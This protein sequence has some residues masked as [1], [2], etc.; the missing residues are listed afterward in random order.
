MTLI[1]DYLNNNTSCDLQRKCIFLLLKSHL[2]SNK[3]MK[4]NK[5]RYKNLHMDH[6]LEKKITKTLKY[7][8]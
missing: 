4:S 8:S 2:K 7:F 6:I 5:L 1:V 3:L